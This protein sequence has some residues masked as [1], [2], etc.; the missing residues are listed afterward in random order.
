M[1]KQ[2]ITLF[3]TLLIS[4]GAYANVTPFCDGTTVNPRLVQDTQTEIKYFRT[5]RMIADA[6]KGNIAGLTNLKMS[7]SGA[8]N[9]LGWHKILEVIH[10]QNHNENIIMLDID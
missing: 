7:G 3:I 4:T 9:A 5:A 1:K 8:P 10:T 2:V 6:Y